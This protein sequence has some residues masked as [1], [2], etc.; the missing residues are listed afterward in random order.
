MSGNIT[1]DVLFHW[2][3]YS[4]VGFPLRLQL[5]IIEGIKSVLGTPIIPS[6]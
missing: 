6:S 2:D 3:S 4:T 5:F 1:L